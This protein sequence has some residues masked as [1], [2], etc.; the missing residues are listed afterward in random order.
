[1]IFLGILHIFFHRQGYIG[2]L[3]HSTF[4]ALGGLSALMASQLQP[5]AKSSF[6]LLQDKS[7][8]GLFEKRRFKF[9]RRSI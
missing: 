6:N 9:W 1:M 7:D 5:S 8:F 4:F 3:G 2:N